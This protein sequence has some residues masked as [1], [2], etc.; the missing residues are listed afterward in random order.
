MIYAII[1]KDRQETLFRFDTWDELHRE[2]FNPDSWDAYTA[3][4]RSPPRSAA[5]ATR[6]GKQMPTIPLLICNI[7][8]APLGCICQNMP[9][10]EPTPNA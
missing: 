9:I 6:N 7:F 4:E 1:E 2:T 10:L 8:W 3:Q 5:G